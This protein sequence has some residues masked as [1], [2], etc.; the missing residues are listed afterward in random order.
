M[1]EIHKAVDTIEA[2]NAECLYVLQGLQRTIERTKLDVQNIDAQEI[3]F[4]HAMM[5]GH[6]G[7]LVDAIPWYCE[8]LYNRLK[9]AEAAVKFIKGDVK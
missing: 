6:Y 2:A 3:Q 7:A 8:M 9:D 1:D 4:K 5:V